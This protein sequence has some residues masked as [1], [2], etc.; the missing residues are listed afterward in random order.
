M[1]EADDH[2]VGRLAERNSERPLECDT[3]EGAA[4]VLCPEC[5]TPPAKTWDP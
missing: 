1:T 5:D 3:C 2:Q 4:A